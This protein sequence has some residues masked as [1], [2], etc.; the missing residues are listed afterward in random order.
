MT[1]TAGNALGGIRVV[2]QRG[3]QVETTTD[4][5]GNYSFN[6]F[7]GGDFYTVRPLSTAFTFEPLGAVLPPVTGDV[8]ANFV[9]APAAAVRALQGRIIDTSGFGIDG[10]TVTLGGARSAV[11]KTGNGGFYAF[12]NLPVGQSYTV[13]PTS[14]DGLTFTPAQKS[15]PSL[16]D[17]NAAFETFIANAALPNVQFA[18]T[19]ATVSEGARFVELTLTRGPDP[20]L[21]AYVDYETSDLTASER[22]DYTVA[23]GRVYFAPGETTQKLRVLVTDDGL[24]EGERAFKV[25]L[26]GG[27]NLFVGAAK[28]A[29][30]RITDDDAAASASNPIDASEFFVRQHYA[31]FLNREPDAAGL[32]FWTDEIESCGANAQCRE[33]KRINVS[34]A[35]FLSI[36]FQQTGYLVY[37][38]H[39]AAYGTGEALRLRTFLKDTREIGRGVVVGAPGW[40]EQLEA[41][42]RAFIEEFVLRPE[43]HTVYPLT[44]APAVF[45]DAL[46]AN[47]GG[48]LNASERDA[49]VAGLASGS[50]TRAQVL[51]AVAENAE[52]SRRQS[53][54]AFVLMQYFGYMRR[55]PAEPPDSDFVGYN[56]WL[57][58]LEQFK[59]NFIEAEMVKAFI[60][61]DEYRKRFGKQ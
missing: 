48:S 34:A 32:K 49:L 56:F 3:G 31:D 39:Q 4:A 43:F 37:R 30:V 23:S 61:S 21:A 53:N 36:E 13:T 28:E 55:G 20:Q 47:T 25:T 44:L 51:R 26:T 19:N 12:N 11:V 9:G 18:Q 16:G 58:K 42:K 59:G 40:E 60:S 29:V 27:R 24:L 41:N 17:G 1:D 15:Y 50:M 7:L 14:S 33:V 45:V 5:Q 46:N 54:R 6:I 2:L 10:V 22:S 52:F 35:F 8:T 38:L 57:S